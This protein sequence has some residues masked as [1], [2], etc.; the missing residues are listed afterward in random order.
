MRRT[1]NKQVEEDSVKVGLRREDEFCWSKWITGV[2]SIGL[3]V[4]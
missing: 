1:W 2:I 4:G 3:P